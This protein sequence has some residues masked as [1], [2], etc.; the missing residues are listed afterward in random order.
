MKE[1]IF[2]AKFD[3]E[4]LMLQNIFNITL[5]E[6]NLNVIFTD[7]KMKCINYVNNKNTIKEAYFLG[8]INYQNIFPYELNDDYFKLLLCL[9]ANYEDDIKQFF[10]FFDFEASGNG[11]TSFF[12]ILEYLHQTEVFKNLNMDL[13]FLDKYIDFIFEE[14]LEK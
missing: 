10:K 13:I 9:K 6:T 12:Y 14:K 3:K 7:L 11:S 2:I 1:A 4:E 8:D 5:S